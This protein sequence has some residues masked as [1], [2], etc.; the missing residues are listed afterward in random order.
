ML[1]A[2]TPADYLLLEV[3]MGGTYDTTNVVDHPL[4]TII[5]PVDFDHQAFLG[6][7]I[8]EI[9]VEQGRHLQARQPRR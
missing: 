5:T 6:N 7:T 2:E 9:A 1:F 3:G 4:G 8:A